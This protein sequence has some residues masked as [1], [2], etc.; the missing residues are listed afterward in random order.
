MKNRYGDEYWFEEHDD[1]I[2][3]IQGDLDHWRYGGKEG[4]EGVDTD[5]LGFV[6][7]SGGPF[8]AVGDVVFITNTDKRKVKKIWANE[9]GVFLEVE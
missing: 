4:T 7:P 3:S 6:D 5:D 9:G 2:Y 8:I 1:N